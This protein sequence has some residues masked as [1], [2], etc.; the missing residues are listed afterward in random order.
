MS[1]QNLMIKAASFHS[2]TSTSLLAQTRHTPV[3]LSLRTQRLALQCSFSVEQ[4]RF[5]T[6]HIY[7]PELSCLLHD[8]FKATEYSFADEVASVADDRLL[9]ETPH[10]VQR[11]ISELLL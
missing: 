3:S 1:M 7:S 4:E 8:V 2:V 5:E 9:Q 11:A 10:P 6:I